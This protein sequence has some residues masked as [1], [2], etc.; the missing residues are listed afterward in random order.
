MGDEEKRESVAGLLAEG[1]IV[2]RR[3]DGLP[4]SGGSYDQVAVTIVS[5]ALHLQTI[6]DELLMR[7]RPDIQTREEMLL[8]SSRVR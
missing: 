5:L 6:E 2:Q 4:G 3:N 8:P 7:V 1:A